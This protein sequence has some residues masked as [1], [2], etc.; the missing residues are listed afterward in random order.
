MVTKLWLQHVLTINQTRL[1]AN[2][3]CTQQTQ[4]SLAQHARLFFNSLSVT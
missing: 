1:T 2:Q 3:N 4:Q